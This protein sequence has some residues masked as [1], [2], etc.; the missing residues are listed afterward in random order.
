[1]ATRSIIRR[2]AKIGGVAAAV[3]GTML[4]TIPV[5]SAAPGDT[6]PPG[7]C[8]ACQYIKADLLVTDNAAGHSYNNNTYLITVSNQGVIDAPASHATV[9]FNNGNPLVELDVPAVA[10]GASAQVTLTGPFLP[11]AYVTVNSRDEVDESDYTNNTTLL[12]YRLG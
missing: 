10:A 1:M 2:L 4:A 8:Q 7:P 3:T 11:N 6:I 5:A 9:T 12:T